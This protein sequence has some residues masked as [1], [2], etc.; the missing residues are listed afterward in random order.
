MF[1]VLRAVFI[2]KERWALGWIEYTTFA[3]TCTSLTSLAL[4]FLI[5]N[6][7]S[8][9]A[10]KI[11]HT[12][13]RESWSEFYFATVK[14]LTHAALFINVDLVFFLS[15]PLETDRQTKTGLVY[16]IINAQSI[17]GGGGGG[18]GRKR[19]TPWSFPTP[20]C[21]P[22]T[23]PPWQ[24]ALTGWTHTDTRRASHSWLPLWQWS[25]PVHARERERERERGRRATTLLWKRFHLRSGDRAISMC[26]RAVTTC[27]Q[28]LHSLWKWKFTTPC[29]EER[30]KRWRDCFADLC[31]VS[32]VL[33][34]GWFYLYGWLTRTNSCITCAMR[35]SYWEERDAMPMR[36]TMSCRAE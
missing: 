15:P 28:F 22:I 16:L 29:A 6:S 11:S 34:S 27:R 9:F 32:G 12:T 13:R 8:A 20:P 2:D 10:H 26:W 25:A 36:D 17:A 30:K 19:F 18:K 35:L 31:A 1:S 4:W 33:V 3:A 23:P 14:I 7:V 21:Y 5:R 24:T